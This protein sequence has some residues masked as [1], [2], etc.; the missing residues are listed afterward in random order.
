MS[1][2][3]GQ[4]AV[5]RQAVN[6]LKYLGIDLDKNKNKSVAAV[7]GQQYL[8]KGAS[9]A[10]KSLSD[11]AVSELDQGIMLLQ[12]HRLIH[13]TKSYE[14]LDNLTERYNTDTSINKNNRKA[15]MQAIKEQRDKLSESNVKH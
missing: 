14:A 2:V 9:T 10:G 3:Q 5:I 7:D 8:P 4:N 1:S 12:E 11:R 15:L 13:E 6:A